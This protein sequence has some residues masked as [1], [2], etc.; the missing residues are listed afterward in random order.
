MLTVSKALHRVST[1]LLQ[2][3]DPAAR[4]AGRS[5]MDLA[6]ASRH[7]ARLDVVPAQVLLAGFEILLTENRNRPGERKLRLITNELR[8]VL[9]RE[10]RCFVRRSSIVALWSDVINL[11]AYQARSVPASEMLR[12]HT[13]AVTWS[14]GLKTIAIQGRNALKDR[15]PPR[16]PGQ[17]HPAVAPASALVPAGLPPDGAREAAPEPETGPGPAADFVPFSDGA[18]DEAAPV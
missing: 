14:I 18:A 11:T 1:A 13:Y 6:R 16:R 17:P 5:L 2:R 7:Y 8:D 15:Y 9:G 10:R 12:W 3:D 4:G